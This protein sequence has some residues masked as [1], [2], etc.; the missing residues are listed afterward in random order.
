[1]AYPGHHKSSEGGWIERLKIKF[2]FEKGKSNQH[3]LFPSLGSEEKKRS[4]PG[5]TVLG[6]DK[7]LLRFWGVAALMRWQLFIR[8]NL[9]SPDG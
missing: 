1:M 6:V 3:V 4:S 8:C 7:E 5:R 2:A 9:E